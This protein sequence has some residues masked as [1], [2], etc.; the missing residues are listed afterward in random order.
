MRFSLT[1]RCLSAKSPA[2]SL[3]GM[4]SRFARVLEDE[5]LARNEATVLKITKKAK[6]LGFAGVYWLVEN[7]FVISC[8]KIIK[9]HLVNGKS[10]RNICKHCQLNRKQSTQYK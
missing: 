5:I 8:N 2:S 4:E 7:Y 1:P 6:K 9:M 3:F 10:P